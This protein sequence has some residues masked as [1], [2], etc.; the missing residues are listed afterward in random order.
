MGDRNPDTSAAVLVAIVAG[1]FLLSLIAVLAL[2]AIPPFVGWVLLSLALVALLALPWLERAAER[3]RIRE[4][5]ERTGGRGGHMKR[6]PFWQQDWTPVGP[7][8]KRGPKYAVEYVDLHGTRHAGVCRTSFIYG[9][10]W[11]DKIN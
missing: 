4:S 7:L 3:S 6:L 8:V 10:E 1:M 2:P 11:L 9:V 5:I